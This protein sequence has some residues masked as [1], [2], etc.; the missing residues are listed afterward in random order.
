MRQIQARREEARRRTEDAHADTQK[1]AATDRMLAGNYTSDDR[2]DQMRR[3]RRQREVEQERAME[4][5]MEE[6]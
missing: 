1:H 2:V 3:A 4:R 6:V 5:Q